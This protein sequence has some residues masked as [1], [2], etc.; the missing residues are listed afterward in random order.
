M[1]SSGEAQES[2]CVGEVAEVISKPRRLGEVSKLWASNCHS[3]PLKSVSRL[4]T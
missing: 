1:Q 2:I 3:T 4:G